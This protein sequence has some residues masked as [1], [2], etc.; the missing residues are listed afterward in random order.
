MNQKY[1]GLMSVRDANL[2]YAIFSNKSNF[3]GKIQKN[4]DELVRKMKAMAWDIFHFRYLEKAS[5]FSLSKNADYFFPA[6]CSF[7]DEFVKLIDFYKLSG[8]VYNKEDSDI[9]P[10]MLLVWMIW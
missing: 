9:Y 7:D 6:L 8:L 5:T 1:L 4:S 3:F 10:F 2:A